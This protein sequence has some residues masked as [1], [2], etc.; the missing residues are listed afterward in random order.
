MRRVVLLS[1]AALLLVCAVRA[2]A[3]EEP[4]A[5]FTKVTCGS[6][7]K[8]KHVPTSHRLHSH[9]VSY[10]TGSGQ[11]SVTGV[12]DA[13]DPNRYR[14][15]LLDSLL[16]MNLF[17]LWLVKSGHGT[18]KCLQ[19]NVLRDG[20]V[21]RFEHVNTGKYLHSHLHQ[22]PLSGQQEVSAYLGHDGRGDTGS[23]CSVSVLIFAKGITGRSRQ[24][25]R[26]LGSVG[27]PYGCCTLTRTSTF[28]RITRRYAQEGS[29][30]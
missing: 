7:I 10:G 12:A 29:F 11:Q 25:I 23:S 17:S 30:F 6:V 4:E 20:D 24:A 22:S 18:A 9:K 5:D 2:E 19:G 28:T 3:E 1:L 26:E 14:C 27:I 21:V 8:L 16:L 13:A 15:S